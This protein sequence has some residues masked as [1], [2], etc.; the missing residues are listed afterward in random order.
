MQGGEKEEEEEWM[1]H[2]VRTELDEEEGAVAGR[3]V[4]Y[5]GMATVMGA[6]GHA[7]GRVPG[8]AAAAA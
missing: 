2:Q 1:I 6:H 4:E 8:K 7:A 5:V 3:P